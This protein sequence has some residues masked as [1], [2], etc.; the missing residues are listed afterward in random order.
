MTIKE[1]VLNSRGSGLV[2]EVLADLKHLPQEVVA[3]YFTCKKVSYRNSIAKTNS[4]ILFRIL[5]QI[6]KL[7]GIESRVVAEDYGFTYINNK[8]IGVSLEV[9]RDYEKARGTINR[10][11]GQFKDIHREFAERVIR[12]QP[13][14]DELLKREDRILEE[15]N[16]SDGIYGIINWYS[17]ILEFSKEDLFENNDTFGIYLV[18]DDTLLSKVTAEGELNCNKDKT[19]FS[20]YQLTLQYLRSIFRIK[21]VNL[22][23]DKGIAFGDVFL[24]AINDP[25]VKK[26]WPLCESWCKNSGSTLVRMTLVNYTYDNG[27][28][29]VEFYCSGNSEAEACLP[30][31]VIDSLHPKITMPWF[32]L[33]AMRDHLNKVELINTCGGGG[34]IKVLGRAFW[35]CKNLEKFIYS[36]N[37]RLKVEYEAFKG[38]SISDFCFNRVIYVGNGAFQNTNLR[39]ICFNKSMCAK[40]NA[41][42]TDYIVNDVL[43]K[44]TIEGSDDNISSIAG[45]IT[46]RPSINKFF[47]G[48]LGDKRYKSTS[49]TN[50]S[51]PFR[52]PMSRTLIYSVDIR[53]L[54]IGDISDE[55]LLALKDENI[56]PKGNDY[57]GDGL[58]YGCFIH[59]LC[60]SSRLTQKLLNMYRLD[61]NLIEKLFTY[62]FRFCDIYEISVEMPK[63]KDMQGTPMPSVNFDTATELND[64]LDVITDATVNIGF[65]EI[66]RQHRKKEIK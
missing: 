57:R 44:I 19:V 25:N 52:V 47:L 48:R 65:D 2:Y 50:Y 3:E 56:N 15:I 39:E 20:L 36:K 64:L 40:N 17:D 32:E 58:F 60:F 66:I 54:Q 31:Q 63:F 13:L 16:N 28:K 43:N 49:S 18:Y 29:L 51:V 42:N 35:N 33:S 24:H 1:T 11:I 4:I 27:K 55:L 41:Y 59:K 23:L 9:T 8:P 62:A 10:H 34:L 53:Q 12:K 21:K 37:L 22:F 61:K 45:G 26:V 38:T 30:A 6:E 46:K 7:E 14:V 5:D